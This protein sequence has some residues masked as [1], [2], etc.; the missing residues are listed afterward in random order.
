MKKLMLLLSTIAMALSLTGCSGIKGYLED[1][2]LQQSGILDDANYKEY[3]Q[4]SSAGQLDTDGFFLEET[5]EIT[6]VDPPVRVTFAENNNLNAQYFA[7][8]TRR[9][10]IDVSNCHLN[11]GDSV[12]AVVSKKDDVSSSMYNFSGFNIYEYDN[13]GKKVAS[14]L[15]M[16]QSADF[17][18]LT[19]PNDFDGAE[20]S[21]EPVG[22]YQQRHIKLEDYYIDGDNGQHHNLDGSW[23]VNDKEC[24]TDSVEISPIISYVI[25]YEYDSDEYFFLSSSPD[26]YYTSNIDGVVIFDQREAHDETVDY[27]VELHKYISVTLVSDMDRTVK[28][29]S[30]DVQNV[31]ANEELL[32]DHLKY[33]DE[34]IL[35]TNKAWTSLENN[36]ELILKETELLSSGQYKYTL[37]VPEK[38]G[39]FTFNPKDY[40]YDHGTI[41]FKC[42]GQ[43]V[44]TTQIL[45][46]GSKI[47]YEMASSDDGYWL[48][49]N[50]S[51]HY[52]VVGEE[53]QTKAALQGIHF[54]P[55]VAVTVSLPQPEAGGIVTYKLNGKRVYSS[56]VST[57]SGET[58]AMKFDP[59]EGWISSVTGEIT[60]TVTDDKSQIVNANGS[61]IGHVFSEDDDH[62]PKLTLGLEKS[63]GEA[64]QFT[65]TASGY[66]MDVESYGGGWKVTDLFDEN[67]GTYDII[68]NTEYIVS[69]QKIGT[70]EPIEITISNKAIQSGTAIRM[71]ITLTDSNKSSTTE[72]RYI[73]DLSNA[74]DPIYI[75]KPQENGHSTIWYTSVEITIGVVDIEKYTPPTASANTRISVRNADTNEVL[76]GGTLIEGSQKVVVMISPDSGYYVT[77]KK[78][79]KDIYSETMTF[80]N[81]LKKINSIIDNHPAD[82][83]YT[84]TLDAS[85]SCAT[86]T[87]KLDGTVVSGTIYAKK[88]QKLELTYEITDSSYQLTEAQGGIPL[89]GWGS[90]TTKATKTITISSSLDGNTVTKST[91]SI[92][93]KKGG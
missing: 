40:N 89:F 60:Y 16:E 50:A 75:Y 46:K 33:G 27:S 73:D 12:Y 36:R 85:D 91:F 39:E 56:S 41:T 57:Y 80:S 70:E 69:D 15:S 38:D 4:Y 63:V 52:I 55:K 81:Y 42:F 51:E 32:L 90:T 93:V 29:N 72:T 88:D 3:E 71:V 17:Y 25:S 8:K 84:I 26:C 1:K 62:K 76:T 5:A 13:E 74:L 10:A 24:Q 28:I 66:A 14:P 6:E 86:Y 79:A 37:I 45:A 43:T 59:W 58:I 23:I 2:M 68:S 7:D 34:V 11:P 53:L 64:M 19:I 30:S 92:N 48:A 61:G 35:E 44:T 65:L 78:V 87:Y 83:Y 49:G 82:K 18:V 67:A 21:L 20:L 9:T 77:G 54:T 47:Y 22:T 31:R